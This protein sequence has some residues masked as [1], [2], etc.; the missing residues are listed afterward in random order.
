MHYGHF[1]SKKSIHVGEGEWTTFREYKILALVLKALKF[2]PPPINNALT[3][4]IKKNLFKL[5]LQVFKK[6]VWL[7]A[8]V[9]NFKYI[10]DIKIVWS[11]QSY[12]F[13]YNGHST[14]LIY[15]KCVLLFSLS[16]IFFFFF[17]YKIFLIN[18]LTTYFF[19]FF[20]LF[21]KN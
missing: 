20:F 16:S 3:I 15:H 5:G 14:S 19:F 4:P 17:C 7:R 12:I 18:L 21:F 13:L 1:K 9:S 6:N 8:K 10:N 11:N 2:L